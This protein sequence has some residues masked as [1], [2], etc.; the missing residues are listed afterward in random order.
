M[1][2]VTLLL[3]G[4][5]AVALVALTPA[6]GLAA[7]GIAGSPHDYTTDTNWFVNGATW[8]TSRTN[9]CGVCHTIHHTNPDRSA[10]LWTH[11]STVQTFQVYSS[12]TFNGG[13]PTINGSS[14]ACLSCHDGSVA[15]NQN[16][17][18]TTNG[19][20]LIY[21]PSSRIIP[22]G[23]VAPG[24]PGNNDLRNM[25]PI[26][27]SYTT[28]QAADPDIRV[29]TSSILGVTGGSI[30]TTML[31]NGNMECASCHDI[32]RTKG[33][34]GSSGIMT[35]TSGQNLCLTCHNK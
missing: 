2:K 12:P 32:H 17:G 5:A 24:L 9:I 10:P 11:A 4:I 30:A 35:I 31:K 34:S 16:Y 13:T 15:L 25:H 21:S 22:D 29:A 33:L 23:G 27:F 7:T 8:A 20:S 3:G 6:T 26:G 28:A 1:K 14:K 19:A 18:G